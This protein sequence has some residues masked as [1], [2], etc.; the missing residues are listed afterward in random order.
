MA[1][2][3]IIN[4]ISISGNNK[5]RESIILRELPFS[6][7]DTLTVEALSE[8]LETARNNLLNTSLFN[9]VYVTDVLVSPTQTDIS[10]QVEERWY[11]WPVVDL[12]FEDRNI[13]T[14]L[15]NP[16]WSRFTLG[17]GG[18]IYNMR[19]AN[20]KLRINARIGYEKG[21]SVSYS[22]I[23]IDY[24]KRHLFG[25]NTS[26]YMVHN[27]A[28]ATHNDKPVY[29][30]VD[31]APAREE[32]AVGINYSYRPGINER[33]SAA[34]Y[35]QHAAIHDTLLKLNPHFWGGSRTTRNNIYASYTFLSDYRDSHVYPLNG[36]LF[37]LATELNF[38]LDGSLITGVIHPEIGFYLP[39]AS[40]LFYAGEL[41]GKLSATNS[42]AY[43]VDKAL[44]YGT[45]YLRGYEDYVTDGQYFALMKNTMRFT[46]LPTTVFE[47]KWLS[48]LSKFNK[49]HFTIY[50]NVFADAGYAYTRHATPDNVFENTF[51]YSG[52]AGIDI[53]TYYDV[54]FRVDYSVNKKGEGGFYVTFFTPFF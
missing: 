34:L 36:T 11:I 49:I 15:R 14:W 12:V 17:V 25:L 21:V 10:V 28:Y 54:V 47:I 18:E 13:S 4:S 24:A 22:N 46:L 26:Y 52:G 51:L 19:G 8:K 29:V 1:Q 35:F 42:R 37:K 2:E 39:L 44:G 9:F 53:V 33:H 6:K 31:E 7:G 5:T 32:Y 23:A 41:T 16:D 48:A 3:L 20:E 38:A 50:A 40:R 30:T 27:T 43:G 45:N